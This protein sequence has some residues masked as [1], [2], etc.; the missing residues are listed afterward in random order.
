MHGSALPLSSKL[1]RIGQAYSPPAEDA[2]RKAVVCAPASRNKVAMWRQ[3]SRRLH[4]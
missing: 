2:A 1:P 3:A 4:T